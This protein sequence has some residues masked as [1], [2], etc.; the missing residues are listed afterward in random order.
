MEAFAPKFRKIRYNRLLEAPNQAKNWRGSIRFRTSNLRCNESIWTQR[1][2]W[3]CWKK[4]L[5]MINW[6]WRKNEKNWKKF[7]S[8]N[9]RFFFYLTIYFSVSGPI[10]G[11]F[12]NAIHERHG[13]RGDVSAEEGSFRQNSQ[14][15]KKTLKKQF[16]KKVFTKLNP[17]A[18]LILRIY[19]E[20]IMYFLVLRVKKI[21][22]SC[23]STRFY[24]LRAYLV[25]YVL[26]PVFSSW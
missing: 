18:C 7:S 1:C 23:I 11:G 25:I 19:Y 12:S 16:V 14:T 6:T 20:F 2:Y 15:D 22:S 8:K 3:I 9:F 10:S 17:C 5:T 24:F 13:I 21:I 26:S 4:R